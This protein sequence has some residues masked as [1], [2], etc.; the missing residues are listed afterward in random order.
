MMMHQE[1]EVMRVLRVPPMGKLVVEVN[2]E[3][4][5]RIDE[6]TDEHSKRRLLAA[7]GELISFA[8]NYDSLVEAGVAPPL[9]AETTEPET[10]DEALTRQQAR[11]IEQL[12]RQR[13]AIKAVSERRII[14]T[15]VVDISEETPI[16][17][18]RSRQSVSMA[19]QIDTILQ[20]LK[21]QDPALSSRI[22]RLHQNP[23]GGLHIEVDGNLYEEPGE[24]EDKAIQKLIRQ[25]VYTWRNM[26]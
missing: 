4:F 23:A 20:E 7:V 6:V 3:R 2:G 12:E 13:D 21:Y 11:F 19:E 9:A 16:T 5:D 17:R 26:Q 25:A 15:P 10:E 24:I 18:L 1:L 22:I 8:G 14:E